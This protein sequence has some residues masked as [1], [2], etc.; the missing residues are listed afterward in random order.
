[1]QQSEV[2]VVDHLAFLTFVHLF[3]SQPQLLLDL[4][5]RLVVQIR[6]PRVNTQYG[7]RDAQEILAR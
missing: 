7:L 4:I 5:H 1:V 3:D 6:Y 2:A